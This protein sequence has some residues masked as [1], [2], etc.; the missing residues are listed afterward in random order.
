MKNL[1]R[2]S[3]MNTKK[4]LKKFNQEKLKQVS[5]KINK[6]LNF[7]ISQ[8]IKKFPDFVLLTQEK[9]NQL[10]DFVDKSFKNISFDE[11]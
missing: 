8:R 11:T 1:I 10:Q 6:K 7:I 2:S 3:H 5:F 9:F 4:I